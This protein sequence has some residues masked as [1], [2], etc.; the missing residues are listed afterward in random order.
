MCTVLQMF[1][2]CHSLQK[3]KSKNSP[4]SCPF[5]SVTLVN[6]RILNDIFKYYPNCLYIKFNRN[7][8]TNV[9]QNFTAQSMVLLDVKFNKISHIL[10]RCFISLFN[11]KVIFLDYNSIVL[12][13]PL[14][15]VNLSSLNVLSLSNNPL[16]SMGNIII[17]NSL[18][19]KMLSIRHSKLTNVYDFKYIKVKIFDT[20]DFHL[21]CIAPFNS[22]CSQVIPWFFSCSDLLPKVTMK[23]SFISMMVLLFITNFI[24][25]VMC[26]YFDSFRK[27]FQKILYSINFTD[28]TFV[29]YLSIIWLTDRTNIGNFILY[30][31]NWRSN[32]ICFAAFSIIT[33]FTITI[34]SFLIFASLSRLMIVIHPLET[35]FKSIQ[36]ISNCLSLISIISTCV[37]LSA[38]FIIEVNME[39]VPTSLCLT[40]VDP[41]KTRVELK[42]L[43]WSLVVSQFLTC[44]VILFLHVYL[45]KDLEQSHQ[46]LKNIQ[47]SDS[48]LV[49]QL[50]ILTLSNF[51]C[52]IPCNIIFIS[53][54]FLPK[55]PMSLVTWTVVVVLPLRSII[56]PLVFI[57]MSVKKISRTSKTR[58]TLLF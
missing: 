38:V 30:E 7:G 8:L 55:Y 37:V 9:C 24:S 53:T 40:F 35:K 39:F 21:C 25:I 54:M 44:F 48:A 2:I 58:S 31:E 12:V 47:F 27:I 34:Q 4:I 45:V 56:T 20:S 28:M 18:A 33:W 32:K 29:L 10:T 57:I 41:T 5:M 1:S 6:V 14:S 19:M 26:M 17:L 23:I 36:F 3:Y 22:Q 43:T 51:I 42:V 16:Y 50:F 13:N 49:I 52:W 11:L 46:V 15:F